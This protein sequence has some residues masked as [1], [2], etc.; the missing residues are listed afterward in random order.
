MIKRITLTSWL[1]VSMLFAFATSKGF[2]KEAIGYLTEH[3]K[4]I[5]L[6]TQDIQD[7]ILLKDYYDE[8]S[9]INRVWF[10]QTAYGIP[11]KSGMVSVH[12]MNGK[13]VN[14][15]NSG[16][17]DLKKQINSIVPTLSAKDAVA[18][19]A[20]NVGVS[21][22]GAI[23][24]QSKENAVYIFKP[25]SG[26]SNIEIHAEL[27]LVKDKQDNVQLCWE[28]QF[29]SLDEYNFWNIDIDAKNGN[30]IN[31]YD[32]VLHCDFGRGGFLSAADNTN[33]RLDTPGSTNGGTDP[34]AQVMAGSYRVYA[35]PTESPVYGPRQLLTNPDNPD[36]SP[37]GWHDTNGVPGPE[38]T[39]TRGNNVY[40]YTDKDNDDVPDPDS[41]PDGGASLVFD[42]PLDFSTK[43]DTLTNSKAVVTQLFYM[44]NIMHDIFFK[45]GFTESNRNFQSK[46]YTGVAGGND[47]VWAE[48]H[49]GSLANPRNLD[50]ANFA[51]SPD[52]VNTKFNRTRMQMY[53]WTGTPPSTLTYLTP[54]NIAGDIT[55]GSQNG[56]GPC[57]YN[58]TGSVV[59]ALGSTSPASYVCGTV[60][61]PAAVSGKI[62]LIDRGDCEFSAKVYNAQLAGAIGVII[63]NRQSAGDSIIGMAAGAFAN[64]VTIPA[65]FVTYAQGQKLRDNIA[66]ATVTMYRISTN[67]CL[68]F[69]GALD[70]AI[71]SHEY[72][73]GISTR[74]TGLSTGTGGTSSCLSNAEQAGEGWSDFFALSLTKKPTDTKNT[75]RGVGN[76][77]V[78][79]DANGAGIRRYPYS[80]DM[81]INPLTYADMAANP[82]VHDIGEIWAATLWDMYWN[83]VEKYGYS[84]DLYN[85]TAGNNRAIKLV[86]EGLK[87]QPCNPGFLDSR[88]A[89]LKADSIL[90]GY[91]DKCEI[92]SAF[93]RRGMGYSAKQGSANSATD[94]TAAYN[95]PPACNAGPTA[96]ASFT[97]SDT[98]V[99][100]G[101]SLTF[102][103]TSTASAGSPDSV[104]WTIAGGTPGTSNS[105]TTVNA[106]FNTAGT[107]TISL[108]AYK[109]GNA[110]PAATQTIRVKSN[111]TVGV[112]SPTICSGKTAT[113]TASGA[114]SY[115]WNPNIGSG[116]TVTTPILTANASYTVTGT[117][118]G[119]VGTA[120]AN[121]TVT[122][123]PNVTVT[124]P[125][126]CSGKTA[127]LQAS[128]ADSYTW[129]GGLASVSNPTTPVLTANTSYTVTG[130][131]GSCSNTAVSNVTV[132]ALP[133]VT[134]TSPTICSGK[135]ATLQ[136]S[137]ADSYT[138][139]G[140]LASV[141]NPTTPV[142]TA[143]TSYTV[144]GTVG[145]CSNT[146]VSNVTVTALPNVT[147]TSPSICAGSTATIQASGADSY[148]W[149]PNIGSGATVTTPVLTA[150]ASYTVTG[151]VGNCSNTAVS[152]VIVNTTAPTVT[153]STTPSSASVCQ[154]ESIQLTGNGA[155]NYSW[156]SSQTGTTT[157]STLTFT[158][159]S[160]ITVNVSGTVTGCSTAGTSSINITV[161]PKPTVTVDAVSPIC[162]GQ[163]AT[164]QAHGADSYTWTGGLASVSNPTTPVLNA[165]A[166]Y[167][168]TGTT[169]GCSNSA[170]VN[171]SVTPKPTV[172][173]D[174][175]SPICSGETATLQAHGA[176]SYTWTGGL[177]SV[178]NP[179]T[180]VLT[181]ST[182]YTVTGTTNNCSNT[183]I[184]NVTVTTTPVMPSITQSGDTLHSSSILV[185]ASYEWYKGG[186]L[187]TTTST[188]YYILTAAG[189]YTVKVKNGN[190]SSES[191]PYAAIYTGVKNASNSVSV[192]EVYPNPTEGKLKLNISLTKNAAVQLRMYSPDGRELYGQ[193]YTNIRV[194]NEE[195]NLQDVAKG[196]YILRLNVDDEVYY[197]KVVKQ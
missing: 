8:Y 111:P 150:N 35:I 93:A 14:I 130:T 140:G 83:L 30:L 58:V 112:N 65:M 134:V 108:V 148:S 73:H 163:T 132:T 50:N 55:H 42:F 32:Q 169:N 87:Q 2:Q 106:T 127:T 56:W 99:C 53:M 70:N 63:I 119:C 95:L 27:L 121:V 117:K 137:G 66:T 91:A 155:N 138:W 151:T 36:A 76:Y 165:N 31:K 184:A 115:T 33:T 194:L 100:Q 141:S 60:T 79:E 102:T 145:S 47:F 139:T 167:T 129:T 57:S 101:G 192:F 68:D 161:T 21:A 88:N 188:P 135:T 82:E 25:V 176:D 3:Q 107:Y 191:A 168:V 158:P 142:L 183:A 72:G 20:S 97:S 124:S 39:I 195:L 12:Y 166:S 22:I 157:G 196:V 45:Y 4:E 89:I 193:S 147:V 136:A 24:L 92:W 69:D 84:T 109:S 146:A 49:D 98:V 86:V 173:V 131:V 1:V 187:Q 29:H 75:P 38:Y 116:A 44:N 105:M 67:N 96:T 189:I 110:S 190:C 122:A 113:L 178:S 152:N 71:V 74:L 15:T 11:L 7:L 26:V 52:G 170:I 162:G 40:A 123:L 133:N 46:N 197:H 153:I 10:Q 174:A 81:T 51:T 64:S 43:L 6:S 18:K 13:V 181:S 103:N 125:T 118:D 54:A 17:L 48:A 120:T 59:N 5:N 23:E 78:G 114:T 179:T 180:P 62:A 85:G 171:V 126:I 144:T 37:Y 177:A 61:N 149:S 104:R 186:I 185:G 175:V 19:A 34:V 41:S 164:L 160:T 77:V 143:N 94:Q 172:T 90:Y 128:G 16:V 80:Y 159:T 154:G 28:V 156:S 9:K 182:S